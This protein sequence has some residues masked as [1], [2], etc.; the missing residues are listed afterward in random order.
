MRLKRSAIATAVAALVGASATTGASAEILYFDFNKNLVSPTASLFLFGDAGQTASVTNLAGFS[1]TVTLSAE[2]FY[3]LAIPSTYQQSGTGTRESGFRVVSGKAIAG[4]FINRASAS[5]DMTYLLDGSALGTRYVIASMGQGFGE[6]GQAAIHATQNDTLVTFTPKGGAPIIMTLQAGETYKYAGGA[7]DITGSFVTSS[8][9]VAVFSGHE[10]A[11]VLPGNTA[12]DTLLEQAIPTDKLSKSYL[13]T[14]SKGAEISQQKSDLVRVVAT[15]NETKV[16]V[17]G[18]EVATIDAGDFYQFSLA[19]KTGALIEANQ[20]VSVAQYLKGT[21]GGGNTDPA[22][23]YVPGSDTWLKAYRLATPSGASAFD[24]NYASIVIDADDLDSLELDG[25]LVDSALFSA[26]GSTGFMRG[27]VDLPIGLF[28]LIADSP[29]L[30]MLGGGESY[31]SYFTYGGSTFAPGVSPP[32]D[33]KP[34]PVPE[35]ATLALLGLGLAGLS[36]VRRRRR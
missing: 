9:P 34:E 4:Y 26:I 12:C 11:Q 27:I 7:T 19:E 21:G 8:K 36:M 28:D 29:F 1:E 17:D 6:G 13:I 23:S 25:T 31:D 33:P 16:L 14:A 20:P 24:V 5:T 32:V 30:V 35:P 2:G 10:C 18:V 22:L 15:V 3:S